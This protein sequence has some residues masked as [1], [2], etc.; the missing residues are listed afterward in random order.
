MIQIGDTVCINENGDFY[1]YTEKCPKG[2]NDIHY[3]LKNNSEDRSEKEN[4]NNKNN[5]APGI[6]VTRHMDKK[7]DE[8]FLMAE[9]EKSINKNY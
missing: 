2:L 5:Y 7:V 9:K 3:E 4:Y 8:N 6:R 1:N